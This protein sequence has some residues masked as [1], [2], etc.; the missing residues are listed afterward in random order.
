[1]KRFLCILLLS[2][3]MCGE[4]N[5]QRGALTIGWSAVAFA[6]GGLIVGYGITDEVS[7]ELHMMGAPGYPVGFGTLGAGLKIRPFHDAEM[8]YILLGLTSILVVSIDSVAVIPGL[9]LA[10]GYE[11]RS[12]HYQW[13]FPWEIGTS[14][15]LVREDNW[16]IGILPL[17]GFGLQWYS[18]AFNRD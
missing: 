17:A 10:Y 13:R 1:M 18:K 6:R 11:V 8:R 9:N 4:A 7:V 15:F 14:V 2:A 3:L 5:A 12:G 16:K